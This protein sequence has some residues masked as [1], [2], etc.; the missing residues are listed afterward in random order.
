M[1]IAILSEKFPPNF[2]GGGEISTYYLAKALLERGH[3]VTVYTQPC[4]RLNKR[5]GILIKEV[6]CLYFPSKTKT[7]FEG[8]NIKKACKIFKKEYL[9]EFEDYDI[10]HANCMRTALILSNLKSLYKKS[11]I[12]VR[13]CWPICGARFPLLKN[14]K[15][16]MSC[17]FKNWLNC[18][19]LQNYSLIGKL[20]IGSI[21]RYNLKNRQEAFKKNK[22]VIFIS[23]YL[24]KIITKQIKVDYSVIGNPIN[25]EWMK[26]KIVSQNK[27]FINEQSNV[28]YVGSLVPT[29]GVD[30]LLYAMKVVLKSN[31]C[32][33]VIAGKGNYEKKYKKLTKDLGIQNNVSFLGQV[34]YEKTI[35]LFREADAL[36]LPSLVPEGFGRILIEGMLFEKPVVATNHGGPSDFI[37]NGENGFLVKPGDKKE[38]AETIKKILGNKFLARKVGKNA[39]EYVIKNFLPQIIAEKYEKVYT[40]VQEK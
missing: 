16:C 39:R 23:N 18:K 40:E 22:K 9:K 37:K 31:H 21:E 34:S 14:G 13:D 36:I 38:L 17:S 2:V 29:K 25:K 30:V 8:Y 35:N 4:K 24:A 20:L 6:K 28:L 15:L 10:V 27:K 12:T 26:E 19:A 7:L 5:E 32:Y 33:L 11:I 1:K 3:Q